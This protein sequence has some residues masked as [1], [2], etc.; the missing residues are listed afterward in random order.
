MSA[1]SHVDRATGIEERL[2]LVPTP[3][4]L[5][6]TWIA[7]PPGARSCVLVCSSLLG[8]FTANYH[9]E[10]ELGR[11][12]S[13]MGHGAIRFHYAG[14]GNSQ[15]ERRDMTFATLCADALAVMAHG[16]SLGFT[17]FALLGTRLGALVAA[18][19]VAQ[20]RSAPIA[21][22]EPTADLRRFITEAQRAQGMSQLAQEQVDTATDWR[23]E[24]EQ[25]GMLDLLGYDIYSPLVESLLGLDLLEIIGSQARPVFI[26]RFRRK[27]YAND[28]LARAMVDR[29]FDVQHG[30]FEMSEA[31]WFH[32]E[33]LS[34]DGQLINATATWL[35]DSFSAPPRNGG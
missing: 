29:G 19:T 8:D 24:L 3:R 18:A 25:T 26:G 1:A 32:N 21:L 7:R 2:E 27:S 22:W 13:S 23:Q 17:E 28:S 9:R 20:S 12:L 30:N 5:L 31:W 35:A 4:G 10:R 15:G 11:A 14:E 16:R 6:Y 34:E 33:H